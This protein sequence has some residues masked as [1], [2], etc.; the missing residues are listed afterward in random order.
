M[1]NRIIIELC[2]EDRARLD[3][4][5]AALEGNKPACDKCVDT[6][7]A[8]LTQ[9]TPADVPTAAAQPQEDTHPINDPSPFP[10]PQEQPAE[11]A[12]PAVTKEQIQKKVMQL[13][14]G[15][16]KSKKE[17][18]RAIVNEYAKKV[19]DLPEDKLPEVW[20]RLIALEG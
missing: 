19:T 8:A 20:T 17:Q 3:S 15:P 9:Q 7:T 1:E 18:V 4:I 16:D 11:P 6:V 10:E 5:I 2:A 13:A 14:T 12:A